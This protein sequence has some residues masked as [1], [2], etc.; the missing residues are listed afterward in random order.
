MKEWIWN[1]KDVINFPIKNLIP[2][3]IHFEYIK[4]HLNVIASLPPCSPW[5]LIMFY[6][7]H[8]LKKKNQLVIIFWWTAFPLKVARNNLKNMADNVHYLLCS[9][10]Q[11]S[12]WHQLQHKTILEKAKKYASQTYYSFHR[13]YGTST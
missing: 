4:M 8:F 13:G 3:D 6:F 2:K 1:C 9:P 5:F 10:N 11:I 12:I 7:I